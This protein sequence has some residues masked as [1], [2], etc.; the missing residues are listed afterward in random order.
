MVAASLVGLEGLLLVGYAVL[1]LTNLHVDRVTM[2]LTTAAFFAILGGG[3][4]AGAWSIT[5]GN[6]RARSPILVAQLIFVGV[7]WSF[8]GGSTTP[9]AIGIAVVALLVVAG[10][11]HPASFHALAD[12][13]ERS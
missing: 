4:I 1:E 7:A 10:T 13:G 12:E 11:L 3:L 2:G 8:R 5:H 9:L 6:P